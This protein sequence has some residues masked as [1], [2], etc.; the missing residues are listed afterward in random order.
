M[1]NCKLQCMQRGGRHGGPPPL[2]FNIVM[3]GAI[4]VTVYLTACVRLTKVRIIVERDVDRLKHMF[5]TADLCAARDNTTVTEISGA[6]QGELQLYFLSQG[7][8]DG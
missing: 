3:T 5:R 1:D 6:L 8:E 7:I 4:H 2:T